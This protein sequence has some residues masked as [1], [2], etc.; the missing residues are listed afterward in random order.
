MVALI[1]TKG[2]CNTL[3]QRLVR[4][5]FAQNALRAN[6]RLRKVRRFLA[7]KSI[8]QIDKQINEKLDALIILEAQSPDTYADKMV[9]TANQRSVIGHLHAL[10]WMLDGNDFAILRD[11][12]KRRM[13]ALFA[14]C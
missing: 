11:D 6:A 9:N 10:I 3:T 1:A 13:D 14:R 7:M 2:I 4:N 8:E 12:T 5:A